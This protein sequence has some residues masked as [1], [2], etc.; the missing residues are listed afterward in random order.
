MKGAIGTAL[1]IG[2]TFLLTVFAIA[3]AL[4]PPTSLDSRDTL[5]FAIGGAGV[6]LA[7]LAFREF[8][9]ISRRLFHASA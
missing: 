2:S 6:A 1:V 9:V 3:F 8:R 4:A 5:V 7:I